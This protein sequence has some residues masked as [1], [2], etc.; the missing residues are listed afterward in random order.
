M[1]APQSKTDS[2]GAMKNIRVETSTLGHMWTSNGRVIKKEG[3]SEAISL[4]QMSQSGYFEVLFWKR[5][6]Q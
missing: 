2:Q 5:L 1:V 4:G 3:A 6:H